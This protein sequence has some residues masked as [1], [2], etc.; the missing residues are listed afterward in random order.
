MSWITPARTHPMMPMSPALTSHH[1]QG[2]GLSVYT[3]GGMLI[4]TKLHLCST[5]HCKTGYV[6]SVLWLTINVS[7]NTL[8][9]QIAIDNTLIEIISLRQSLMVSDQGK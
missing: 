9:R 6:V 8:T 3:I 1:I 4:S 2:T 7:T 5:S